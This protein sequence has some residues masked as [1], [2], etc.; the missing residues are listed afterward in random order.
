MKI[1]QAL[2]N[3]MTEESSYRTLSLHLSRRGA[4]KAIDEH[5]AK[6]RDKWSSMYGEDSDFEEPYPFGT[7][8]D[9]D[10]QEIEVLP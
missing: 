3:P 7:F 9:W 4:Q 2:Y 5:K 1:Y 10:V 8:K 6:E